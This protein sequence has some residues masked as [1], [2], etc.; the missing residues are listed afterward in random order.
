MWWGLATAP[1]SEHSNAPIVW[2]WGPWG[3]LKRGAWDPQLPT[4]PSPYTPRDQG[5]PVEEGGP[6]LGTG[7]LQELEEELDVGALGDHP[8]FPGWRWHPGAG[9]SGFSL[10]IPQ[11]SPPFPG[12][13]HA[14]AG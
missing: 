2:G 6:F 3:G 10:S 5:A 4:H 13:P 9:M 12:S 1:R 7:A 11:P 8:L 14:A